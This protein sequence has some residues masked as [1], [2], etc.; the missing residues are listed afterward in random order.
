[1]VSS[2]IISKIKFS[3]VDVKARAGFNFH[4]GDT[5]KVWSKIREEKASAKK[6]KAKTVRFRLQAFEGI[7]LARKHGTEPGATFTVRQ[8][9]SGVGVERIFPL[10]SPLVEKIEI[11]KKAKARRAKLYYIRDRAAKS[12]RRKMHSVA[13]E[14]TGENVI[15]D[16]SLVSEPES[17]SK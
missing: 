9:A 12:I 5:I 4:A 15:V 2:D 11:I 8:I 3:P 1:M 10:Y 17:K 13:V 16:K 6:G 14:N 7:V